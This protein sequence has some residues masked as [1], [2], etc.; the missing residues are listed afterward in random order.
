MLIPMFKKTI[1]LMADAGTD[2]FSLFLIPPLCKGNKEVFITHKNHFSSLNFDNPQDI[3]PENEKKK[4]KKKKHASSLT[5][6]SVPPGFSTGR[7]QSMRQMLANSITF[8]FDLSQYI[9]PSAD[10]LSLCCIQ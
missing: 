4:T 1:W 8:K 3:P 6:H 9:V 2:V 7:W 5:Q 10:P